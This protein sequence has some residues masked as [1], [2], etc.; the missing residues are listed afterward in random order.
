MKLNAKR[1][2]AIKRRVMNFETFN[3][4]FVMLPWGA[5]FIYC[6][7]Y[8]LRLGYSYALLSVGVTLVIWGLRKVTVDRVKQKLKQ[9]RMLEEYLRDASR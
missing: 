2:R 7:L 4:A 6:G 8:D 1:K 5:G 9:E 3:G